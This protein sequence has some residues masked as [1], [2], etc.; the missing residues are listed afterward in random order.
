MIRRLFTSN[1]TLNS[2]AAVAAAIGQR[3]QGGQTVPELAGLGPYFF[4]PYRS[5]SNGRQS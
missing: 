4:F 1:V 3:V 5:S 2:V